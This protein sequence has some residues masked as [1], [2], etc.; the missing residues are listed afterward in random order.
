MFLKL[1][2]MIKE[3]N[4]LAC[5][6][7]A[8]ID[9]Q[10]FE[11]QI[12]RNGEAWLA[13]LDFMKKEDLKTLENGRY[14]LCAGTYAAVSEYEAKEPSVAKYEV[15]RKYIDIQYVAEGEEFI[16]MLPMS[17]FKEEQEYNE[18]KDIVFFK[19]TPKGE[20][21]LADKNQFFIFFPNEAHRPGI[22]I[23]NGGKVKKIVI[24]IPFA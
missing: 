20:K 13:A 4:K 2:I 6:P 9:R 11:D 22:K 7:D 17:D 15:H 8:S 24:K 3:W 10:Q 21:L 12:A 5:K 18:E 23:G 1:F 14:E 16:E 19:E